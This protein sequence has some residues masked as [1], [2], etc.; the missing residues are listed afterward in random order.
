[1]RRGEIYFVNLDPTVGR[2]QAGV[3]PVLVVSS[4]RVNSRPLVVMVVPGTDGRHVRADHPHSVRVPP[5]DSGLL[6]ETIF[7]CFQTRALDPSRFLANPDD[8]LSPARMTDVALRF[9]L[10]LR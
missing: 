2:E 9:V 5:D 7:L 10:D 4:D 1:M 3:R 6:R 8:V